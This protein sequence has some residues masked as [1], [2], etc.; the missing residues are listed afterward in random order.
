MSK[1]IKTAADYIESVYG[2]ANFAKAIHTNDSVDLLRVIQDY[3][4][5]VAAGSVVDTNASEDLG[6]AIDKVNNFTHA[7]LIP[8]P[9]EMHVEQLKIGLPEVVNELQTAFAAVTG[10]NPWE[11]Q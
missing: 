2:T 1:N 5:Y 7:L 10:K 3:G 9:A 8:L 6:R 4:D 11:G